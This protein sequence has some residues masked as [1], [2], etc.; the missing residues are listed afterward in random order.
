MR[1]EALQ[2]ARP[3]SRAP[4][5]ERELGPEPALL[6]VRPLEAGCEL[7]ITP[8][9]LRPA[10]HS[11]RRLD[12][13]DRGN[14]RGTGQ[15]EGGREGLAAVVERILLGDRRT[16]VGAANDYAPERAGRAPELALDESAVTHIAIVAS[17][18]WTHAAQSAR[19]LSVG[20]LVQGR[21]GE[22]GL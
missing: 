5:S 11:T 1:V 2:R 7:R 16:S 3:R 6:F 15:V 21:R 22:A 4:D 13:R 10:L 12:P 20:H 14:E 18:L 17:T 19:L 8:G 9:G